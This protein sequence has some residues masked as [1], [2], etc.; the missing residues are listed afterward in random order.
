LRSP[1][2]PTRT[3]RIGDDGQENPLQILIPVISIKPS[4][5]LLINY[6]CN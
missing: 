4:Q 3:P 2:R 6:L 5:F 1:D